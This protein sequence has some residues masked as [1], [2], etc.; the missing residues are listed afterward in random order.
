M[1]GISLFSGAGGF[2]IGLER[3]G[4]E[5]I[6][7]CEID[8]FCLSVLQKHYPN[9][10]KV[11]DVRN[12]LQAYQTCLQG[13]CGA[14]DSQCYL[15]PIQCIREHTEQGYSIGSADIIY[16]G[17]PC[18]DISQAGRRVGLNGERSGL[19]FE[20]LNIVR[21]LQPK[22]LLIENVRGLLTSN[23]GRDLA[24]I[25]MGLEKCGYEWGYRILD[26]QYFGVP[27]RRRRIYI[28][29]YLGH[30]GYPAKV[31]SLCDSGDW[32]IKKS[33]QSWKD[34]AEKS[35]E[36]I[37]DDSTP[38][39]FN[40]Q[41]AGKLGLS[42]ST[43]TSGSIGTSQVPPVLEKISS[44]DAY[45]HTTNDKIISTLADERHR[46][47][48]IYNPSYV[49]RLMPIEY[50]RL[51]S[52]PDNWT[53]YGWNGDIISDSQRYKMCGNGVVS[54]VVEWIGKRLVAVD[55]EI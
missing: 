41:N 39:I 19:W 45:N 27:Q 50:E 23:K 35:S 16:G 3:A 6:I 17:F 8:K 42:M 4:I 21:E 2:E 18:Q 55:N 48:Y 24:T 15:S 26:A 40:R 20:F 36:G 22:W 52:W 14:M 51:F 30:R 33:R 5:T 10:P 49:R 44:F 13:R 32:D 46:K 7:Q 34:T 53:K 12:F 25:L 43:T 11:K 29:G 31:L 38:I 37:G 9:V 54:N 47:D 28:V 1:R